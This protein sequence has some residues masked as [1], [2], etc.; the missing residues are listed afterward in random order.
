MDREEPDFQIIT[1]CG[2][3]GIEVT[4]FFLRRDITVCPSCLYG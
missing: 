3:L 4:A 1:G 2:F